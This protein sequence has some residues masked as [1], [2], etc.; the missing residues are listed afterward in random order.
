MRARLLA[1]VVCAVLLLAV[2]AGTA[3]ADTGGQ[4]IGQ[5][6]LSQQTA[7]ADA[8]ST[9]VKPTN[10]NI[11]VRVLSPG[12]DGTVTQSNTSAALAAAAN[13]NTTGQSAQQAGAGAAQQAIGQLAANKQS[14][15]AEAESTQVKPTNRNI[16]VRV[17]SP[18]DDGDVTQSN[19]SLAGSLAANKNATDQ[20]ARQSGGGG[21]VQAIGQAAASRQDA[22]SDAESEQIHP[23]N[24]NVPVRVLS[25]GQNGSVK[26]ENTSAALSAAL[27]KDE[28]TQ[29]AAQSQGGSCGCEEARSSAKPE[30]AP[31][32]DEGCGCQKD[33][34][35]IQAIGQ[36]AFNQQSADSTASSK[37]IGAKNVNVPVRVLSPGDEGSVTQRND[38]AALS[39]AANKNAT[40]QTADQRL[41]GGC[42][43]D[44]I[45]IQAIGQL[46]KSRQDAQSDATSHQVEPTNVNAPADVLGKGRD[47]GGCGCEPKGGTAPAPE[48]APTDGAGAPYGQPVPSGK[49][50]G[51]EVRARPGGSV[52]QENR[53]TALSTGLNANAI[54]QLAGQLG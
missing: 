52:D 53:S 45:A 5:L 20:S 37:Q 42:G 7:T 26:Q 2:G 8:D 13:A 23:T 46:A 19:K 39:L 40:G 14:A 32:R 43:C 1:W 24:V 49:R 15:D 38:S 10:Q 44:G 6:A 31:S 4:D 11:S 3:M 50:P 16:S 21:G 51:D 36:A 29:N 34:V 17:L 30:L 48:L 18:G 28:T 9:Q 22:S 47:G 41:G 27:N 25:P 33:G 35:A 54:E 12:D